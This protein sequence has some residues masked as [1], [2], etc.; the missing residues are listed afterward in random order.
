MEKVI[1]RFDD[2]PVLTFQQDNLWMILCVKTSSSFVFTKHKKIIVV[3]FEINVL[4]NDGVPGYDICDGFAYN[5]IIT[6]NF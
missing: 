4:S 6:N 2:V 5:K 3:W 1:E